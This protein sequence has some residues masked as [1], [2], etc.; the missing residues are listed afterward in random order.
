VNGIAP[1]AINT[2]ASPGTGASGTI[3]GFGRS[4][5]SDF[6]YGLKRSGAVVLSA[7]P[8]AGFYSGS[9]CWRYSAPIG[10]PG[11][12]ANT[13]NADSGGPLFVDLGAGPVVAG[14]TSGGSS[15]D[16][17]PTDLSYDLDVFA[18]ASFIQSSGGADLANTSCGSLPQVGQALTGVA[19]ASGELSGSAPDAVHAF[20]VAPGT[21]ML[22]VAMTATEDA[23]SDFD[24]YVRHGTAPT[25]AVYDCRDWGP[26][27]Y[28]YCEF[29]SP[30]SGTWYVLAHRASGFGA[31]Q[32]T[33]TSFSRDCSQPGTDGLAC[34]DDNECTANDVCAAGTCGGSAVGNGTPCDDGNSCT[35]PDSCAGGS[36]TGVALDDGTPCDDGNPCSRPDA[37]ASGTCA[38]MVPAASC[39]PP[40]I[41]QKAFFQ[42]K[43]RTPNPGDRMVWRW[44]RGTQTSL[45]DFGEP[46]ISTDYWFCAYDESGGAAAEILRQRI[47]AGANWTPLPN[48]YRYR[49]VNV[50]EGG[51]SY[52]LLKQGGDGFARI[53]VNGKGIPLQMPPLGLQQDDT[54]TVQLL[55]DTTCWQAEYGTS[56]RNDTAQFRAR[57]D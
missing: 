51:V 12:N 37:C 24:L 45:A 42:L 46:A 9:V 32:V 13:C 26:N 7:C 14:I 33:V 27:Q 23:D 31:Y 56:L 36:C 49:D 44:L 11:L 30:A 57:A 40:A 4:G 52:V 43:D 16:C 1:S 34:N 50:S 6:D 3:V 28:S 21:T 39:R 41:A 8:A 5:G 35:G 17:N 18:Q 38:G 15:S 54:V 19:S 53:V 29:A 20:T 55:N 25:T 48:G 10:P 22:R 2:V 47:P